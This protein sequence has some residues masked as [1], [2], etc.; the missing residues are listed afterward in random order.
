MYTE[1]VGLS[2]GLKGFGDIEKTR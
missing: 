2:K 1:Y